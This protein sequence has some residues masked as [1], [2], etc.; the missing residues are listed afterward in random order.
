MSAGASA[1]AQAAAQAYQ[2]LVGGLLLELPP[3]GLRDVHRVA[4]P[5]APGPPGMIPMGL[6]VTLG[7]DVTYGTETSPRDQLRELIHQS[8]RAFGKPRST[9]TLQLLAEVCFDTGIVHRPVSASTV[10]R[11]L[12]RMRIRWKQSRL[13]QT[14]PDPHYALK[15]ARRDRLLAVSAKHPDWVLGFVDEVWWSRL[16]RPR[17]QAWADGHPLKMHVLKADDN[18]PDPIAICCYGILRHDTKKVVVRFADDRPVGDITALFLE[19]VCQILHEE[20]KKRLIVIWDDAPR[21][22]CA[23]VLDWTRQHNGSVK[24]VGGVE[25]I[26]FELP[27]R[28]PWL[29]NIE[30][31]YVW[32]K[33][34]IV[35][36]DRKLSEQ[37]TVHRV[38]EHF[39]CPLLPCLKGVETPEGSMGP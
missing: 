23:T 35:E 10:G 18:D 16:Q 36:P 12:Q 25:I 38:C 14:S 15:K 21:H 20:G 30:P 1:A 31:C 32:V 39:G 17:M 5:P 22:A 7:R 4:Q 11:E 37:E 24:R 27:V 8:P 9:W 19:W 13:W 28:S 26:H 3:E 6:Q 29:N 33:R 2:L 34:A